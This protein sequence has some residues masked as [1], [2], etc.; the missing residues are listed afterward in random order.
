MP[1]KGGEI[2]RSRTVWRDD[3]EIDPLRRVLQSQKAASQLQVAQRELL[4]DVVIRRALTF[5][6]GFS[7]SCRPHL[8]PQP[9][10]AAAVLSRRLLLELAHLHR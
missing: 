9:R 1:L 2:G 5:A 4:R 8:A 6:P 7:G 3:S 10:R